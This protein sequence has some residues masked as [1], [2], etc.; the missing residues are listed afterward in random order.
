MQIGRSIIAST[1][2][3]LRMP[4]WPYKR[5]GS[6]SQAEGR[7]FDSRFPLQSRQPGERRARTAVKVAGRI[8]AD[9]AAALLA[10]VLADRGAA[11][12]KLGHFLFRILKRLSVIS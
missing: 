2:H 11:I 8:K 6:F 12:L 10:F 4:T 1:C 5:V 9:S 7:G 3:G